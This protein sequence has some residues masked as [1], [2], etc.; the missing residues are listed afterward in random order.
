MKQRHQS[1]K[2]KRWFGDLKHIVDEVH[3][4][5]NEIAIDAQP[6][7]LNLLPASTS[8]LLV[9]AIYIKGFSLHIH[10]NVAQG[11]IYMNSKV[12]ALR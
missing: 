6:K 12:G 2:V 7:K 4:M 10:H 9:S 11:L 5:L 8:S 1:T 3:Q